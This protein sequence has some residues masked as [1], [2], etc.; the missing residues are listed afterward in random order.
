MKRNGRKRLLPVL[1]LALIALA[2]F[3]AVT[4]ASPSTKAAPAMRANP[5]TGVVGTPIARGTYDSLKMER[6]LVQALFRDKAGSSIDVVVQ[7]HDY[8]P[9]GSTG[10]HSHP[11]PV[12]ITVTQGQIT[13]YERNDPS[14]SP[15]VV[16]AGQGYVDTGAGHIGRNESGQPAQDV[17]VALAPVGG[18]FRTEL[19]AP[20]PFCSF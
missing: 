3:A 8:A 15:H 17:V 7:K 9:G 1:A 6:A 14:C 20:G 5:P 13:F 4:K 2:G 18:A 12:L 16:S 19:T 10:W 11:G